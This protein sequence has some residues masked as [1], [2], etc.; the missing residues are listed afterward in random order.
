MITAGVVPASIG[1]VTHG[2]AA[3]AGAVARDGMAGDVA[4]AEEDVR[5]AMAMVEAV[6]MVDTEEVAT[7]VI[8][9]EL[10]ASSRRSNTMP[11]GHARRVSLCQLG[12]RLRLIQL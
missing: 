11:A 6:A 7:V 12:D 10:T 5:V 8:G 3:S 1:A 4:E 9:S 2:A